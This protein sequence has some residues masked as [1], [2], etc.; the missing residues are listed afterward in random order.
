MDPAL[1]SLIDR[2]NHLSDQF[3]ELRAGVLPAVHIADEDP[4]MALIRSRKVLE[5]VVRDV[6]V[7]RVGEPPGTRPLEN[8][9]QR[10]VKEG[11]FPTRLEAYTETIRKLGNI[12]AHHFGERVSAS[13]VYQSLTQLMPI[14]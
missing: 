5:Y 8:L 12:G 6:F 3:G 4:E 9:I 10:L 7:R 11:H 1:Q 14:L 13:D 2:L